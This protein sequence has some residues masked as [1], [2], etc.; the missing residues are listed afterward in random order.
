LTNSCYYDIISAI[1]L[2]GVIDM[3]KLKPH[4]LPNVLPIRLTD[5]MFDN[6]KIMANSINVRPHD[7]ARVAIG[8][9][10]VALSKSNSLTI[11]ELVK[12]SF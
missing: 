5:E 6:I 12:S 4:P 8:I 11:E 9:G 3:K 7:I 10:L 2:T 1:N